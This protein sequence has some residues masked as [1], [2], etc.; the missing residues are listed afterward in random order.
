MSRKN[1]NRRY[2]KSQIEARIEARR[3]AKRAAMHKH[4]AI[5]SLLVILLIGLVSTS[6][7]SFITPAQTGESGSL[8]AQITTNAV[9]QGS[10]DHIAPLGADA[11]VAQ[12]GA[13]SYTL[14]GTMNGWN[15]TSTPMTQGTDTNGQTFYYSGYYS[16]QEQFKV[17]K[18]GSTWLGSDKNSSSVYPNSIAMYEYGNSGNCWPG[19]GG[20][21]VVYNPTKDKISCVTV[22]PLKVETTPFEVGDV[23][24]FD[25]RNN[26]SWL[27]ADSTSQMYIQFNDST[28]GSTTNRAQLTRIGTYLYM[29]E[30][31]SECDGPIRFW[32]GNS[33]SMWNHSNPLSASNGNG[34]YITSGGWSGSGTVATF[35]LTSLSTPSLSVSPNSITLGESATLSSTSSTPSLSYKIGSTSY[36][37]NTVDGDIQYTFKNGT[38]ALNT[39]STTKS[40]TWTPT[41]AGTYS[42]YVTIT[43]TSTGLSA[44]SVAQTLTVKDTYT[45]SV[46]TNTSSGGTAEPTSSGTVT[47][48][49]SVSI[50]ATAYTGYTFIGWTDEKNGTV[51]NASSATTSFTP[52][53]TN[54]SVKANF[55][56][57][58]PS[59][60]TLT[61][62][63]VAS[64]TSGDGTQANPYI[65]FSDGGFT[66]TAKA[67]VVSGATAYYTNTTPDDDDKYVTLGQ[68][69]PSL[70]TKGV[71][72]TF[73]VYAKAYAGGIFSTDYISKTAYYMV[74]THLDGDNTGFTKS[75]DSITDIESVTFTTTGVKGVDDAEKEYITQSYQIS[76]DNATFSNISGSTWTPDTVGT[77]YFRIKTTNTKTGETVYSAS[78]SVTVTQST[79]YYDITVVNDGTTAGTVTLKADGVKITDGKILSNSK[80]TVSL[81][82]PD[83]NY[84]IEY[85]EVDTLTESDNSNVNGNITDYVAYDHVKGNVVIHY[86]LTEKPKVDVKKPANSASISF[87]YYVDGVQETATAAGIYHVD[88]DSDISYSVTPNT[89]YY[90]KSMTGVEMGEITASTATGT[91]TN[92]RDHISSDATSGDKSVTASVVNNNTITV[93]ISENATVTEGASMTID[94]VAHPFGEAKALNYGVYS[95]LVI[96]PPEGYYASINGGTISTD[97]KATLKVRVKGNNVIYSVNFIKNPKIYMVQPQYGSVYVTDGDGNYYFNGD[98]VGYGTKLTVHVKPDHANATLNSVLVND[99]SIGTTDGSTFEIK[100]DSTA[101][102]DITVSSDFT[103]AENTEYGT[104]R[105]FYTD[106]FTWGNGNVMV[107]YS[108]TSNDTDFSQNSMAMTRKYYN[109]YNQYVY[110]ADIPFSSKYLTFYNKSNTSQKTAQTTILN[111]KNAYYAGNSSGYPAPMYSWNLHYSD[112]VASDRA[113]SIQQATTTKG[114]AAT[115]Q[116]TCDFGDDTL[117]AEVVSGNAATFDF[118]KGTLSITPTSN[119]HSYTL[120]KVTSSASTTVKYY[121]IRVE[122]FEL[123]DFTGLQKIYNSSVFNKIQLDIIVKGGVLNYAAKYFVSDTNASDSYSEITNDGKSSGFTKVDS[124]EGYINSFLVEYQYNTINGVKYYRIDVTDG[125]NRKTSTVAK[126]LFGTNTHTGE[127]VLYFYND[128]NVNM[129]KYNLRACFMS[130][131][132]SNKTFVTM[133]RVGSSDYYRAVIPKNATGKVNFYLCNPNTFSNDFADYDGV[134]DTKEFYSFGVMNASIPGDESGNIVYKAS[135]IDSNGIKGDFV[136]FDY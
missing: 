72:Q 91:K 110:Y 96:T 10:K 122:N 48:G 120:V 132:D 130:V 42:T 41:A 33:S 68:F 2:T 106:T 67:T 36:S 43:S 89:G 112:Y 107:H 88:Y 114:N 61:G 116:Y 26:T 5:F 14:A 47:A 133:Q 71:D 129:S 77:Y 92:V 126:T 16:N 11:D 101:S 58:T 97:G 108:N 8:I 51:A 45:Y 20:Y 25:I 49:E 86:K 80:L 94:G 83:S 136:D 35:S 75:S 24:Y 90:V 37:T 85:L 18:N 93:K 13:D 52:I 121:L 19:S 134:N 4:L 44:T 79:V 70:A 27:T 38:T 100:Q 105:I 63:N 40:Y 28:T 22:L 39:A 113:D 29:Y 3:K 30:F 131:D 119:T 117:I 23:V 59:A 46:L 81:A 73:T 99:A 128:T 50:K 125:A 109:E 9:N 65:V 55:R 60:L 87:K 31:T 98:S 21:Y 64:G 15:T 78:Q 74:F 76:T 34:V 7:A 56:P 95:E 32:R 111:D 82:R 53:A 69:D 17:V 66:L 104:R 1:S 118:D 115:F 54:A 84:Y 127:R 103:F 124:L 123:L 62:S 102:A 57:N 12:T 135:T 6:F